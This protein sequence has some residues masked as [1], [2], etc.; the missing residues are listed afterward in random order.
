MGTERPAT[1]FEDSQLHGCRRRDGANVLSVRSTAGATPE[2]KDDTSLFVPESLSFTVDTVA[3]GAP[4]VAVTRH[5]RL[6][7]LGPGRYVI[8]ARAGQSVRQLGAA[9]TRGFVVRGR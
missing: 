3:P 8:S 1:G 7:T 2:T 6:S 9:T 5:R 4:A